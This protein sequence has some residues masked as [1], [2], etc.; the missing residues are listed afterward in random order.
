LSYC[1]KEEANKS[2]FVVY[3]PSGA[4]KTALVAWVANRIHELH[5]KAVVVT[6]FL[7]TSP[8]SSDVLLLVRSLC[9]QLMAIL[10]EEKPEDVEVAKNGIPEDVNSLFS[11]LLSLVEAKSENVFLFIDSIDQLLPNNNAYMLDWLPIKLPANVH[12]VVS[13]LIPSAEEE[14]NPN[15]TKTRPPNLFALL[16]TKYEAVPAKESYF[17]HIP[18]LIPSEAEQIVDSKLALPDEQGRTKTLSPEQ[19]AVVVTNTGSSF[20]PLY[21][22]VAMDLAVQWKSYTPIA[23]CTLTRTTRDIILQLFRYYFG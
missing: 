1:K 17:C 10:A 8:A 19:K 6:R 11:K 21:L 18:Q 7:G 3:A 15:L 9:Q 13:V 14:A 4:G 12:L 22:S 2:S 5:P 16:Q 20:T 23:E